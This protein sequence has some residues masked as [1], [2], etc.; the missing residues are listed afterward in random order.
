[1][2]HRMVSFRLLVGSEH[3]FYLRF[4]I[5]QVHNVGLWCCGS[6]TRL[7][8]LCTYSW[9]LSCR[10]L[11]GRQNTLFK[12]DTSGNCC[13]IDNIVHQHHTSGGFIAWLWPELHC[14]IPSLYTPQIWVQMQHKRISSVILWDE[15]PLLDWCCSLTPCGIWLW[16]HDAFFLFFRYGSQLRNHCIASCTEC[17][18]PEINMGGSSRHASSE[19]FLSPYETWYVWWEPGIIA[20]WVTWTWRCLHRW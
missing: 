12:L 9:R 16:P 18:W 1:M 20:I 2:F 11:V 8:Q 14:Y 5:V 7:H 17:T 13:Q 15:S 19:P 6:Y 4:V 10:C 3:L